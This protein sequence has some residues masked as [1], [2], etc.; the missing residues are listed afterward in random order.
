MILKAVDVK[1]S[2]PYGAQGH[3]RCDETVLYHGG[4]G[5]DG[6][7]TMSVKTHRTIYKKEHKLYL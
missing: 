4:G 3:F 7:V 2:R 6:D 5:S 1:S